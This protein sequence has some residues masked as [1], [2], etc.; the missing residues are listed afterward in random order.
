MA[1]VRDDLYIAGGF[2]YAGGWLANHIARWDGSQWS[3]WQGLNGGGASAL[4]VSGGNVYV[5]GGFDQAGGIQAGKSAMSGL[6]QD[7]LRRRSRLKRP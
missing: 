3:A 1:F 2:Y 6:W 5:G 7:C 4:T